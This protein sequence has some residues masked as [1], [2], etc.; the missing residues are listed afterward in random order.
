MKKCTNCK[1]EKE[2]IDF[3]G[4]KCRKDGLNNICRKCSNERSR[5][6]YNEKGEEHKKN[7][8][9]RNHKYRNVI[10]QFI[11]D[12]LK[13]SKCIDCGNNDIRVLEFDH[14]PEFK[15]EYNISD[16]L[17]SSLS[18]D[19]IELEM[20]KCEIVCANCHRIRSIIRQNNYKNIGR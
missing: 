16:M 5:K 6:Y 9:K 17:R 20:N 18:I 15:K 13:V 1:I 4:N 10:R 2:L 8:V 12:K 7:V 19:S 11:L 3:N 14:L